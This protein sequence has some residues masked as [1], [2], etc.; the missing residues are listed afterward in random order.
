MSVIV[1]AFTTLDGV[2]E[3]PDGSAGTPPGG[4]MFRY[5][6]E[7]VTGDK[8]RLGSVLD[9]GV[10][11]LGRRTWQRFAQLWPHRDGEFAARMNAVP[12]LVASRTLTG[13]DTTAWANSRVLEGDLIEAVKRERR[14]VVVAGS[15][16]VVDQLAAADLVDE[17]RLLTFPI[18]L[19]TGRRL[20][21]EDGPRL[22]L[23]CLATE[24]DGPIVRTRHG[25]AAR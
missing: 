6:R 2:V 16:D 24:L 1:I 25:R 21:P 11:L 18:L 3:D 13:A 17:Y 5:G 20:F 15:F 10:L 22:E 9:D 12:K 8:F 23:E 19:G 4:W 14:D 7:V